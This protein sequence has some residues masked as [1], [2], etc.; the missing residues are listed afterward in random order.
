MNTPQNVIYKLSHNTGAFSVSC[1]CEF[2][3]PTSIKN[4]SVLGANMK[5]D[6]ISSIFWCVN[7]AGAVKLKWEPKF[8]TECEYPFVILSGNGKWELGASAFTIPEISTGRILL[9]ADGFDDLDSFTIII[10]GQELKQ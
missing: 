9:D 2:D 1:M 5:V 6:R 8:E 7:A 3:E 4:H 10:T